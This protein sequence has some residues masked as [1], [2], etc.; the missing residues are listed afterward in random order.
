[1]DFPRTSRGVPK[2]FDEQ[3]SSSRG[4]L[5][6]TGDKKEN[7]KKIEPR[8]ELKFFCVPQRC[9][10]FWGGGL[11]GGDVSNRVLRVS[12]VRLCVLQVGFFSVVFLP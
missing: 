9:V 2:E 4:G 12:Y 5:T 3:W 8:G 7:D 10:F 11:K 1:M 6:G